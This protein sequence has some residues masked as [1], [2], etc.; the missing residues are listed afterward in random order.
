[1]ASRLKELIVAGAVFVVSL[2]GAVVLREPAHQMRY[3]RLVN[4]RGMPLRVVVFTPFPRPAMRLPAVVLAQPVNTPTEYGRALT[5]ELVTE[6]NQVLTFDWHGWEPAENRQFARSGT[7]EFLLLDMMAAVAY[8]RSLPEV[9]PDRIVVTGHSAGGT[10]AIQ[11]GTSDPRI[12]A[13]AAI[14]MEAD[15]TTTRPPNLLWALGLYDEF[16]TPLRMLDYFHASANTAAGMNVTVGDFRAGTARRLAVSPTADHFTEL[17]DRAL[18]R[19]IVNWF[20]QATGKPTTARRFWMQAREWLL[21]VAW[22]SGLLVVTWSLLGLV[23]R[24]R[25]P[26]VAHLVPALTLVTTVVIAHFSSWDPWMRKNV[27]QL[28]VIVTL[29]VGF[30]RRSGKEQTAPPSQAGG[31]VLRLAALVWLSFFLTLVVNNAAS[32]FLK[33]VFLVWAPVFAVQHLADLAYIYTL[34]YPHTLFFAPAGPESLVVRWWVYVLL[35]GESLAPGIVLESLARLARLARR[36]RQEAQPTR[37]V[38]VAALVILA[39]LFLTLGVLVTLRLQEGFLTADSALAA[40]RFLLRFAVLPIVLFAGL[41]RLTRRR[42]T[43]H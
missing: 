37:R 34:V 3:E 9:D 15:V 36:Q 5:M 8:L 21:L 38:P 40:G 24:P 31:K 16:R 43:A 18:H 6:G 11:A 17:R 2:L 22:L 29:T 41:R 32:Y 4:A 14:G 20:N 23:R 13:V 12:A 25:P 27:I 1:M 7:P 39:G 42:V 26:W 10:L 19:E 28:F 30:A 35:V 33:P